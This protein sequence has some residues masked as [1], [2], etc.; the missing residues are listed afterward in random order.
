MTISQSKLAIIGMGHVGCA[1]AHHLTI[2]NTCD[3]LILINRRIEKAWSEA[4]DLKHSLGFSENRMRIRS[5]DYS[6]CSDADIVVLSVAAPYK[7][8]YT[9]L[10]ML[11]QATSIVSDIVPK[12]MAS[13]FCGIFIV[14]TNP[15]DAI[16]YLVHKL[17]GLSA[18]KVIGTGTSLDSARLRYFLADTM[19]V[20]PRSVEAMCMG[21]HGD[22]QM[23]PWSQV[24]VGA[25][26]FVQIL[27][28]NP[29]RL[30]GIE[31]EKVQKEISQIAYRVVKA[32]GAT[33]YGIASVAAKMIRAIIRDG[34]IVMPASVMLK[35]EY[36]ETDVYAGVP[37]VITR[38]GIKELVTYHLQDN[39]LAAFKASVSILRNVNKTMMNAITTEQLV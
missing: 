17:S 5:G 11:E 28:D 16:T 7:D 30:S 19:E 6:D 27:H 20:D 22:S 10:D 15:V 24:T 26:H 29:E 32:K 38:N 35:G 37:A 31:I 13:G 21:E 18:N 8:G 34:N 1:L 9:R 39:E 12:V 33:D 36:G 3:E 2:S 4:E 14:I 23:I 25:K